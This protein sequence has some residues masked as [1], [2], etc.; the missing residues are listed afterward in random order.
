MNVGESKK[1][2]PD[3]PAFFVACVPKFAAYAPNPYLGRLI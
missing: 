2:G 1:A 3:G